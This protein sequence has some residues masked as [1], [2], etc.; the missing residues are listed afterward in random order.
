M[1]T[2]NFTSCS[3]IA[4]AGGL[5]EA[6]SPAILWNQAIGGTACQCAMSNNAIIPTQK[7]CFHELWVFIRSTSSLR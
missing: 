5:Q 1:L 4:G 3:G 6:P 7:F 2:C